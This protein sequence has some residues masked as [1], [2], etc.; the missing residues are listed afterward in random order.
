MTAEPR[1]VAQAQAQAQALLLARRASWAIWLVPM[2]WMVNYLIAL[3]APG[4]IGPLSLA[5]LRWGVAG[6][7]LALLSWREL[8]HERHAIVAQ[9]WQYLTLGFFGM[10]VC[11]AGV[12]LAAQTTLAINMSLIYSASPALIALGSVIWLNERFV[13]RQGLGVLLAL[14]GVVHVIVKGQW[15]ALAQVHLVAGDCWIFLAMVAWALY[16]L[17]QKLWP[18]ALGFGAQLAAICLA[19]MV[20]L[21]PCAC[22]ELAQSG[23]PAWSGQGLALG[24]TAALV[25]GICAYW[26]YGWSQRILGAS[27]VA[28][29]LYLGP[30]YSA[31]ASWLL[32]GEPL[33]WHHLAGAVLILSGVFLVLR[34]AS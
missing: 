24:L 13:A 23:T 25:P 30:L 20:F 5:A 12:Y 2:L 9:W 8:W 15:T 22:W 19:S 33:G 14:T 32:L 4:V 21:L 7:L 28:M 31:L 1:N 29:T 3:R 34:R 16:A 17:L 11:G 10:L 26:I 6:V 27:K 18:S